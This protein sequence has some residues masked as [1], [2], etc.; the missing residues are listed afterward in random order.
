MEAQE[1]KALLQSHMGLVVGRLR[2]PGDPVEYDESRTTEDIGPLEAMTLIAACWERYS[3]GRN[4]YPTKLDK[5]VRYAEAMTSGLWRWD[6]EG[7]PIAITDG[8]VTGGRHRL[9][10]ILLSNTTHRFNVVRRTTKEKV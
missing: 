1:I 3:N 4:F 10:A 8:L 6:P 7:D 9:H 2:L 5:I